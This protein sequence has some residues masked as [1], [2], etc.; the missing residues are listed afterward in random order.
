MKKSNE[1]TEQQVLDPTRSLRA[2]NEESKKEI[3]EHQ[4]ADDEL[5]NQKEALQKI[6][7]NIPM[8]ITFMGPQDRTRLVNPEW[9]RTL[10]WTVEEIK[11]HGVDIVAECFPDAY[12]QQQALNFISR[13][14]GEWEE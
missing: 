4:R 8:M 1:S 13:S 5:Y 2:A 9:E 11:Q 14:D 6:F 3:E 7:D 12:D 10:G